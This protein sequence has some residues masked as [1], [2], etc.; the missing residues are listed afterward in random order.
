MR[1]ENDHY[2][3][4][5]QGGKDRPSL[6]NTKKGS[7]DIRLI[8]RSSND[9]WRRSKFFVQVSPNEP[10]SNSGWLLPHLSFAR[11]ETSSEN[12]K[13][14]KLRLSCITLRGR[15]KKGRGKGEGRKGKSF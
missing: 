1:F 8:R 14:S 15:R 10:T 2:L 12:V 6:P 13:C 3:V 7:S 5:V 9:H 4:A 11:P